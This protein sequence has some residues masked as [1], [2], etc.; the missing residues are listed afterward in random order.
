[1]RIHNIRFGHACNSSSTHSVVWVGDQEL[2]TDEKDH[3]GWGY[4][5]AADEESRRNYA[6]ALVA[7]N[8]RLDIPWNYPGRK[9]AE[10]AILRSLL[11][12]EP[13]DAQVDHQSVIRFPHAGNM[14]NPEF[15]R[16]FVEWF[17]TAPIAVLG[18]NDND[19]EVH[20]AAALTEPVDFIDRFTG[21]ARKDPTYDFWTVF[22]PVS[23]TKVRFSF[24]DRQTP[25]RASL[26]ELVDLKI[27]DFCPFDCAFCY[28]GSTGKGKHAD[29][30]FVREIVKQIQAMGVFEVAIGGGE[31]TFHPK[32][33]SILAEIKSAGANANFTT[34]SLHWLRDRALAQ[35]ICESATA[36]AYSVN[37]P[38][39]IARLHQAWLPWQADIKV[40]VQV[41]VGANPQEEFEEILEEAAKF[42]FSVTLLGFKET[43]RGEEFEQE[44]FDWQES[45]Q[46]AWPPD[47]WGRQRPI[48]IDTLLT[49]DLGPDVPKVFYHTREGAFSAY[50]DAVERRLGPSSYCDWSDMVEIVRFETYDREQRWPKVKDLGPIYR[51]LKLDPL[52]VLA[53][54]E[55]RS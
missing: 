25:T 49:R 7:A 40:V 23:G 16:E 3:F 43:G 31:P 51:D 11:G 4:F 10:A 2:V 28:M 39:E 24:K 38:S 13:T 21:I 8:V 42:G 33:S 15:V 44:V 6:M 52:K 12:Q 19:D 5:T 50:I 34:K 41:V 20:P 48:G 29:F 37:D 22:N 17:A 45:V 27:T 9:E 46:K 47:R 53:G 36:F 14:V 1:M 30:N 18:G 55:V 54:G 35:D 26:P 32:F